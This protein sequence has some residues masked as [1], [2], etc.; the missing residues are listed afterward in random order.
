MNTFSLRA[1]FFGFLSSPAKRATAAFAALF[2][3][4]SPALATVTIEVCFS[5][6]N[7]QNGSVGILV[8]DVNNDG[9][10]ALT[11]G[12]VIGIVLSEGETIGTS[13]DMIVS[14][15]Q[16]DDGA[17]WSG[18]A[19]ILATIAAHDYADLGLAENTPLILYTFPDLTSL[20][21]SLA[22]GDVVNAYRNSAAGGS[23]GDI[24]F[25]CPTDPGVYTL[26]ALTAAF[27]GDFDPMN[28]SGTETV[29]EV[30]AGLPG[31]GEGNGPGDDSDSRSDPTMLT[32]GMEKGGGLTAGDLD[33]FGV[34]V[35]G[36]SQVIAYTTGSLDTVGYL[37]G[38]NGGAANAPSADGDAGEELNFRSSSI[39]TEAGN[40]VLGVRGNNDTQNGGYSVF[41][42]VIPLA[43]YR[44]DLTIGR[45]PTGQIG[46]G[47][48]STAGAGQRLTTKL[49]KV[50]KTR[51]FFEAQNDGGLADTIRMRGTRGN[52][53]FRV[54]YFQTTGGFAN[55]TAAVGA[56]T[57]SQ[58]FA[59]LERFA[60]RVDS[61][62]KSKV[63]KRGQGT[64]NLALSA[65]SDDGGM[66]RSR[67]MVKV[68]VKK[69][70]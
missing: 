35:S 63:R 23:G 69:R 46:D 64:L 47:V 9:F 53:K 67:R 31:G 27:G 25:A 54:A 2:L 70:R 43:D 17:H 44:T 21:A 60:F 12:S 42:E 62:G 65:T 6:G 33:Y 16:A 52:T 61:K 55:V 56:G 58:N 45:S 4:V 41:L 38:P 1:E 29:D 37:Y 51:F 8:A 49:K 36:L 59:P 40:V 26:A 20:G 14:V 5:D 39:I 28:P 13:D 3:A 22:P 68:K 10:L 19:G 32:A 48:Y 57:Y 34:T 18:E 11:D 50:K 66:D 15:F 24:G 7:L 30:S